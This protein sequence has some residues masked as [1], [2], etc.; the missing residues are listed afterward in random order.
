[1]R[2]SAKHN[3]NGGWGSPTGRR[4]EWASGAC[5]S[6]EKRRS[7][8]TPG[9]EDICERYRASGIQQEHAVQI[10]LVSPRPSKLQC[11]GAGGADTTCSA[12]EQLAGQ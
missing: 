3:R 2:R 5:G 8:G 6:T 7:L 11:L 4:T 12:L 1:M 9:I 10:G